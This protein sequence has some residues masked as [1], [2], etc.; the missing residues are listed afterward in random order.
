LKEY[1]DIEQRKLRNGRGGAWRIPP[2]FDGCKRNPVPRFTVLAGNE[3]AALCSFFAEFAQRAMRV[4]VP[5]GH[6]FIATNPLLSH[7]VYAPFIAA[8]L[9]KRGEIIRLVQTLRGGDQP[10]NAHKEF[11]EVTVMPRSCWEPWGLFRKPCEG[12][13]Q[14]NLRKW[15]TGGLRRISP[16][17]PFTD[18]I[19]SAPTRAEERAIA[20]HPSLKPQAFMRHIVRAALPFGIGIVFDPFMGAGSTIGAALAV[21]TRASA[22]SLIRI[23]SYGGRSYSQTCSIASD[24]R[25]LWPWRDPRDSLP[26]G[27]KPVHIRT[28]VESVEDRTGELVELYYEQAN[29]FSGIVGMFGIRAL[30]AFSPYKRHKHPDVAQQRFPDLS[31][32]GRLNP[33][34]ELA[35]E[36]KGSTRP[37]V[38]QSHY[39]HPGWYIIWRYLVDS[40]RKIKS[41]K[42]VVIWRVDVVFVN[43]PDWKY[44]GTHGWRSRWR[45]N[46]YFRFA[47]SSAEAA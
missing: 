15:K 9:E 14:D 39:D 12:R 25:I 10:K 42:A 19:R 27:L 17:E 26:K 3:K 35:L 22:S 33:P 16:L 41:G 4:L 37:W 29:V 20:P 8:G 5:G 2:S 34:P 36:S 23:I 45:K 1:T 24:R 21:A 46:A 6:I 18:V 31:L 11:S 43:K 13:V 7:L 28:A 44:E 47:S 30:D 38:V 32:G 40:T